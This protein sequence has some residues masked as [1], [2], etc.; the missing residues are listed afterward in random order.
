MNQI[1]LFSKV[2]AGENAT[3]LSG[4]APRSQPKH[5]YGTQRDPFK[6]QTDNLH[7]RRLL[8]RTGRENDG[9]AQEQGANGRT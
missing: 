6:P 2:S 9:K 5:L 3:V 8:K 7:N 1:S 4:H